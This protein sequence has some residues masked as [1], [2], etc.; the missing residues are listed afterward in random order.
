M[1]LAAVRWPISWHAPPRLWSQWA[2]YT[3]SRIEH[4]LVCKQ[5][6]VSRYAIFVDIASFEQSKWEIVYC[7]DLT[8][9]T[10]GADMSEQVEAVERSCC[11]WGAGLP[12]VVATLIQVQGCLFFFLLWVCLK[13]RINKVVYLTSFVHCVTLMYISCFW[14]NPA[15]TWRTN[16]HN[17]YY[18]F[19]NLFLQLFKVY[20]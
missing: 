8:A 13:R 4:E 12:S 19:I 1:R 14:P 17:K 11:V 5:S 18:L 7:F 20:F 3:H 15:A 16:K 10:R 9:A 6:S 2:K